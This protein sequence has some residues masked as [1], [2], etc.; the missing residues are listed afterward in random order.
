LFQAP[1]GTQDILPEDAPRWWRL[2]A[3]ARRLAGLYG[4][5]EIRTPTFEDLKLF[6]RGVGEVTDIVEKEIYAFEDKG[7]DCLALRPEATAS[8]V[9]AYLQHGMFNQPQP[10]RLYSLLNLFRYDRPQ[11][12]RYREFHQWNCEVL[13]EN[14][15]LV[16]AE[17]VK[18]LWSYY[19]Q[20]GLRG[21]SIQLNSIGDSA[22]RPDYIKALTDYYRGRIDEVCADDRRR[23]T[24]NPL[25]LL[26]CKQPAC[27]PVIAHAPRTIDFLCVACAAHFESLQ[28]MLDAAGLAYQINPRLVRGLDYYTRTVFEVWP[29]DVGG[30]STLGGGGRYDGLAEQL[31]GRPTP[32]VGFATGLERILLNLDKQGANPPTPPPERAFLVPLGAAAKER[33][34]LLADELRASGVPAIVGTGNRS[35][36][37]LLKQASSTGARWAL[38]LGDQELAAQEV[39]VKDLRSGEQRAVRLDQVG[40][41]LRAAPRSPTDRWPADTPPLLLDRP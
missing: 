38:I 22:C 15:P 14:D 33:L 26:D 41:L 16:D 21:L 29:P 8:V 7:H 20:L 30:Q 28:R 34:S 24:V 23:L 40:S 10:V 4:F 19:A 37:A 3:T 39:N 1:R 6:Q 36:K 35:L 18:L 17:L 27:Q 2:E 5:G 11:S 9:R 12:G 25:R 31:G 32:A 13:G